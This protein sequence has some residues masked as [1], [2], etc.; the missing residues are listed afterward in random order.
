MVAKEGFAVAAEGAY[1][2][3]LV[4]EL[5]PEL[6]AEGMAREFVRRT[7]DLRKQADFDIADRIQ[8]VYSASKR[9]AAA[10]EQYKEFILGETLSTSIVAGDIPSTYIKA[11][12]AFDSETISFGIMKNVKK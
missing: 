3:A 1:L 5:T 8:V 11:E 6:E 10:I 9:L 4:T 7:Q 12:D 2:A